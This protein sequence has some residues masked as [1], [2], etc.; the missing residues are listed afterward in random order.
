MNMRYILLLAP[1]CKDMQVNTP[2]S[3]ELSCFFSHLLQKALLMHVKPC[4]WKSGQGQV[5]LASRKCK[6]T[7]EDSTLLNIRHVTQI[8]K[9]TANLFKV[10]Q[11]S[12]GKK[13]CPSKKQTYDLNGLW[14][15]LP[16]RLQKEPGNVSLLIQVS[17]AL[18]QVCI[19]SSPSSF[20]TSRHCFYYLLV[21]ILSAII[22]WPLHCKVNSHRDRLKTRTKN[23]LTANLLA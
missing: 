2:Y 4:S 10:P 9:L 18:I 13:R 14:G 15:R 22:I 16:V 1:N 19:Q 21:F 7:R 20:V 17:D 8:P 12:V 5:Q 3:S 23:I 11:Q 6:D